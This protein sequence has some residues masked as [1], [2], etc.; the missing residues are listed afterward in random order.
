MPKFS[1]NLSLLLTEMPLQE[2]FAAA[3]KLGFKGVEIQFP[4]EYPATELA[5]LANAAGVE[6]VLHNIPAGDLS[7]GDVGIAG[8]P[9]REDEFARGLDL[10]REYNEELGAKCVNV[11]AGKP[12]LEVD[13]EAAMAVLEAN[14]RS[15]INAFSKRDVTILLEPANGIDHPNFLLQKTEDAVEIIERLGA[16]N[17]MI[18]FDVY[19]RQ[20]MQ[21]NLIH[22]LRN[23]LPYIGHIQFADVPGRHEPGTGEINFP[24]IFE[25]LDRIGYDGWVGAEYVPSGA[26]AESLEWFTNT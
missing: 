21:G 7:A 4:Y 26:T 10:A 23:F 13:R 18:Q 22:A 15:V 20:I 11:L 3:A 19:H 14:V 25:A 2:R 1:I 5:D 17:V 16:D 24:A 8:I 6:I 12:P 9:G